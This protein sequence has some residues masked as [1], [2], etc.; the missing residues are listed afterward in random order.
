MKIASIVMFTVFLSTAASAAIA[1]PSERNKQVVAAFYDLAFNEHKPAEAM[2]KYVGTT[3][4]QHNPFVADGK[5]P[6]IAYFTGFYRNHAHAKTVVKRLIADGEYVVVHAHSTADATD[7]GR[8]VID[9]FRLDHGKIVEHWDA[10]QAV[11]EKS[12][13]SNTMF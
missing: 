2:E 10:A 3:Y 1:L 13:N 11:P 7:R 9:I 4:T 8:A 5:E 6:F 12:V